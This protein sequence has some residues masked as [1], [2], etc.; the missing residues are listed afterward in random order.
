M[1]LRDELKEL[2]D[3]ITGHVPDA[4]AQVLCLLTNMNGKITGEGIWLRGCENESINFKEA[5]NTKCKGGKE[6]E[7][8]RVHFKELQKNLCS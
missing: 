6:Y 2:T 7:S 8:L 1:F 5:R 3:N 4:L